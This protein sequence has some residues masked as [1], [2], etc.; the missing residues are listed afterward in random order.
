MTKAYGTRVAEN[1][2]SEFHESRMTALPMDVALSGHGKWERA[3]IVRVTKTL[4]FV[5]RAGNDAEF[6]FYRS[7]RYTKDRLAAPRISRLKQGTP[8]GAQE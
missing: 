2:T 6:K 4:L 3:Q 1:E 5:K 7:G 8:T